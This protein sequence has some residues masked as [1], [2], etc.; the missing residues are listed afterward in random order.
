VT[1]TIV[2]WATPVVEMPNDVLVAP[3]ETIA[4]V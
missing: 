2:G 1:V 3:A 4:P